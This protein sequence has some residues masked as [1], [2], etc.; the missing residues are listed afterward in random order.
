MQNKLNVEKIYNIAPL[1]YVMLIK[2]SLIPHAGFYV[3]QSIFEFQGQLDISALKEAWKKIIDHYDTHRTFFM[4][5]DT[6]K[7]L[8]I[9]KNYIDLPWIEY[10]W[11]HLSKNQEE[12]NLRNLLKEDRYNG[13]DVTFAPLMRLYLIKES[14]E[15]YKLIWSR[16]HSISDGWSLFIILKDLI[17]YYKAI[18]N[19]I[20]IEL[21]SPISYRDYVAWVEKKNKDEAKRFWTENL[22]GILAPTTLMPFVVNRSNPSNNTFHEKAILVLNKETSNKI[23]EVIR[24]EKL[25]L[26][27]LAQSIWAILLSCYSN[28]CDI[29]FGAVVSIRPTELKDSQKIVGCMI[30]T[31]PIRTQIPLE[32]TILEYLKLQHAEQIKRDEHSHVSLVEIQSWSD[33]KA[34]TLMFE[35]IIVFENYPSSS[36]LLDEEDKLKLINFYTAEQTSFPLTILIS[37]GE[38]ISI[39]ALYDSNHF[40]SKTIQQLLKFYSNMIKSAINDVNLKVSQ[41]KFYDKE[42]YRQLLNKFP[43]CNLKNENKTIAT[44]FEEQVALTPNSIAIYF[45]NYEFTYQEINNRANQLAHF[46]FMNKISYGDR[47]GI[48]LDRTDD[49]LVSLLA[50]LKIGAS[51]I[52]IDVKYPKSKIEYIISDASAKIIIT[53]TTLK[54]LLS[55]NNDILCLD[56]DEDQIKTHSTSN[57]TNRFSVACIAY[58]I[59]TSGSTG[60]SK[61]IM[62]SHHSVVTMLNWAKTLLDK[63]EIM[64]VLASTSICFDLSVYELFL[65]IINGGAVVLC[66][67]LLSLHS[68]YHLDKVTL[69]NTVP[70]V[71]ETFLKTHS[72]PEKHSIKIINLAGEPL[73]RLLVNRIYRAT[74][75]E[76]IFNLYGPSEDT[77]YSTF[78][79]IDKTN[80]KPDIG[81]PIANT[82]AYILNADL[83]PIPDG[84][85]GELYLAGDGLAIGYLNKPDLTADCFI[86]NPF[87]INGGGRLYRT[88]DIVCCSPKQKIDYIGRIDNQVKVR[89]FRIELGEIE[90]VLLK[91]EA[92]REAIVSSHIDE[93]GNTFLVAYFVSAISY[94]INISLLRT[95]LAE[96]LPDYM[97]PAFF[98]ELEKL[99]LTLNGKID[100]K[101]LTFSKQD[102]ENNSNSANVFPKSE[103]EIKLYG[104]WEEIINRK[105]FSIYDNFFEIGGNSLLLFQLH[106]KIKK[107]ISEN[108]SIT[109][110]FK[111]PT[112]KSLTNFIEG[113]YI[114]NRFMNVN[115]RLQRRAN[116]NLLS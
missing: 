66:E 69:I 27:V 95:Q 30:N 106:S 8:Q 79:L 38:E 72:L 2:T 81:L 71:M 90:T 20:S 116:R 67:N 70:S 54:E 50:I 26:N 55:S 108:V 101:A 89:G 102:I 25:T 98:I 82:Q 92:I 14:N 80:D 104:I 17:T 28:T 85:Y 99:P 48:F 61:G 37:P 32:K 12:V 87:D 93:K 31:V 49:L 59:Y 107:N 96:V 62:I 113:N 91:N 57:P 44:L 103:L 41:L 45:N 29:M 46:L 56:A 64:G 34:S 42:E 5:L 3:V 13:Y 58:L 35:S 18:I 77:T 7:P 112:I 24:K 9:V 94:K 63:S 15:T 88:G 74:N 21:P 76:K 105:N 68:F 4:R 73:S 39:K 78:S 114:Q 47:V 52:P 100:R 111:Y 65:P 1:Q 60:E 10:D 83:E 40:E 19:N 97:I 11:R 16:H 6:A 86:P 53:K 33:V 109:D 75:V 36:G 51:Y 22:S 84:T 23:K 110:L 115:L 43:G